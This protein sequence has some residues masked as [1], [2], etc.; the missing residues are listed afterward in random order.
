MAIVDSEPALVG[1]AAFRSLA[2]LGNWHSSQ[3]ERI[4][5]RQR[6]ED[7]VHCATAFAK[8]GPDGRRYADGQAV[9]IVTN[10]YGRWGIQ[11]GSV[12][13]RPIGIGAADDTGD[14]EAVASATS[15]LERWVRARDDADPIAFRRLVHLPFVELVGADLVVHRSAAGLRRDVVE[16]LSPPDRH[17]SQLGHI[18]VRERS[19]HKVTLETEI[20]RLGRGGSLI[21]CEPALV[22]VTEQQGRWALQVYSSFLT[23]SNSDRRR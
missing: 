5:I 17:R 6:S 19:A 9:Y 3:L 4:D 22:I 20:S 11:I 2:T 7:K 14:A 12:T 10:R 23:S 18:Q 8:N 1:S 21:A 15:V 16:R 13:L